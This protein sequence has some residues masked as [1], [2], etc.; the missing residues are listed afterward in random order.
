MEFVEL[1][2]NPF[3]LLLLLVEPFETVRVVLVLL[4]ESK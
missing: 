2:V 4:E 1:V 3:G